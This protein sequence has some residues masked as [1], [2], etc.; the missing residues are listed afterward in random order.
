MMSKVDHLVFKARC[1]TARRARLRA[2]GQ[3]VDDTTDEDEE[4]GAEA[5]GG[6]RQIDGEDL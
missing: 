2:A 5:Q 6:G 4:V 1:L 3:P